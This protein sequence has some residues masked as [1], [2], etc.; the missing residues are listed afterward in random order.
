MGQEALKTPT[1]SLRRG[2]GN[3]GWGPGGGSTDDR[4]APE[5]FLLSAPQLLCL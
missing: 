4:G 5:S 1:G 2:R 3:G